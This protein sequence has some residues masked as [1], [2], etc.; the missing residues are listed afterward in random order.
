MVCA[1]SRWICKLTADHVD[2][3][4]PHRESVRYISDSI[5]VGSYCKAI[6][7]EECLSPV[8]SLSIPCVFTKPHLITRTPSRRNPLQ[9]GR[10]GKCCLRDRY[11][12]V[13]R[14]VVRLEPTYD[15][16]TWSVKAHPLAE[17]SSWRHN[18]AR[19]ILLHRLD[20][21]LLLS[22]YTRVYPRWGRLFES[23]EKGFCFFS[24]L[25]LISQRIV[26]TVAPRN[27]VD[28]LTASSFLP[29]HMLLSG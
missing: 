9:V 28:D 20:A 22:K 7:Q 8:F 16:S 11:T 25:L 3:A 19:D 26:R 2:P 24:L 29:M 17:L 4:H 18:N 1:C 14:A 27:T 12:M 10:S 21:V 13:R 23:I 5:L 6:Q 15:M